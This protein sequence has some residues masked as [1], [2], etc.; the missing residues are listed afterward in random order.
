MNQDELAAVYDEDPLEPLSGSELALLTEAIEAWGGVVRESRA[1]ELVFE[2][3]QWLGFA[4][5]DADGHVLGELFIAETGDL[6][7]ANAWIDEQQLTD[8]RNAWLDLA[9]V[10]S[11]DAVDADAAGQAV[12]WFS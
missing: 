5:L 6:Q 2:V 10:G 1:R 9:P 3:A 11:E 12:F 7:T 4:S 8:D